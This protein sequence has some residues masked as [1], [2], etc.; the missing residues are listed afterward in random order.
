MSK[1]PVETVV[2]NGRFR[3]AGG[4]TGMTGFGWLCGRRLLA[5]TVR[6]QTFVSE[7]CTWRLSSTTIKILMVSTHYGGKH[8][9]EVFLRIKP[10]TLFLPSALYNQSCYSLR[11]RA[12]PF[13]GRSW[14]ATMVIEAGFTS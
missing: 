2:G 11:L 8:S 7:G 13:L 1:R 4:G 12:K 3:D 10:N 14:L 5:I 6:E 9:R